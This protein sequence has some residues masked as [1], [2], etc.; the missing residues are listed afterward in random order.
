V[1]Y[2]LATKMRPRVVFNATNREHRQWAAGY[3]KNRSWRDCPVSFIVDDNSQETAY[4]I[5]RQLIEFYANREF[6][7]A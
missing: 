4:V 1:S 7:E 6:G 2:I 5:E 3:I